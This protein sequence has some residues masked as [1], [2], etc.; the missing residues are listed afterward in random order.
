MASRMAALTLSIPSA[1]GITQR[2]DCSVCQLLFEE[3]CN[4]VLA[5]HLNRVVRGGV[6]GDSDVQGRG[7]K[8]LPQVCAQIG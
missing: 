4:K 5:D 2:I 7:V 8:N 3:R 1:L 6:N